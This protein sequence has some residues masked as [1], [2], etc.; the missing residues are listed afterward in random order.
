MKKATLTTILSLAAL[1]AGGAAI[2]FPNDAVFAQIPFEEAS[3]AKVQNSGWHLPSFPDV[4]DKLKSPFKHA[5][6]KAILSPFDDLLEKAV[7]ELE[8]N[9]EDNDDYDE[10]FNNRFDAAAWMELGL[11]DNTE[12][13]LG[14]NAEEGNED[15]HPIL[16]PHHDGPPHDGPPHDAPPYDG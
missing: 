6:E 11:E 8:V 3:E 16:G 9:E 5:P 14:E 4:T 7:H 12:Q 1:N 13:D 10:G 2:V 15:F